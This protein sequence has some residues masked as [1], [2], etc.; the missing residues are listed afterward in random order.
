[1]WQK[2]RVLGFEGLN[3]GVDPAL[4][5]DSELQD[6][7]N[8]TADEVGR[9]IARRGSV[10][11]ARV[12]MTLA[13][14][15][16]SALAQLQG[17]WPRYLYDRLAAVAIHNGLMSNH[18]FYGIGE[19]VTEHPSVALQTDRYL[20][21]LARSYWR[22][23]SLL[24]GSGWTV[25]QAVGDVEQVD[26]DPED[27]STLANLVVPSGDVRDVI[28]QI[29]SVGAIPIGVLLV[30]PL[31][32]TGTSKQALPLLIP[33]VYARSTAPSSRGRARDVEPPLDVFNRLG[34]IY[35]IDWGIDAW[36]TRTD[37]P[38]ELE[39]R[40][41][42]RL[43]IA[44]P[45]HP[46]LIPTMPHGVKAAPFNWIESTVRPVQ[47]RN[48]FII[49]TRVSAITERG[50]EVYQHD[51]AVVNRYS[52]ETGIHEFQAVSNTLPKFDVSIVEVDPR[53]GIGQEND[54]TRGVETAMALYKFK[55]RRTIALGTRDHVDHDRIREDEE[56]MR[57]GHLS[58]DP[59]GLGDRYF[60][61]RILK[62][63][64]QL[65]H[66]KYDDPGWAYFNVVWSGNWEGYPKFIDMFSAMGLTGHRYVFTNM[67]QD[68]V[69]D[70]IGLPLVL[71]GEEE[72]DG[73]R[74]DRDKKPYIAASPVLW[75]DVKVRYYPCSG[76]RRKTA[77]GVRGWTYHDDLP[78]NVLFEGVEPVTKRRYPV[79]PDSILQYARVGMWRYRFVWEYEDGTLSSPSAELVCGDLLWSA[80]P[81]VY[82]SDAGVGIVNS[83]EGSSRPMLQQLVNDNNEWRPLYNAAVYLR[84]INRAN[85]VAFYSPSWATAIV[86]DEDRWLSADYLGRTGIVV[87]GTDVTSRHSPSIVPMPW[88]RE[89]WWV[90]S[91]DNALIRYTRLIKERLYSRQHPHAN[92]LTYI[93]VEV[94]SRIQLEGTWG[95][96]WYAGGNYKELRTLRLEVDG[97]GDWGLFSREGFP[98]LYY[99]GNPP[100]DRYPLPYWPPNDNERARSPL[101]DISGVE[102]W[103][104]V[105]VESP[106]AYIEIGDSWYLGTPLSY[107]TD[108]SYEGLMALLSVNLPPTLRIVT[109]GHRGSQPPVDWGEIITRGVAWDYN[110]LEAVTPSRP[111]PPEVL[112]RLLVRGYL[113]MQLVKPSW[114]VPVIG[115]LITGPALGRRDVPSVNWYDDGEWPVWSVNWWRRRGSSFAEPDGEQTYNYWIY[116]T[117]IRVYLKGARLTIPEQ[118]I[119]AFPSAV[120]YKAP[121]L[122]LKIPAEK[123]PP[124]ARRL[125]IFRTLPAIHNSDDGYSYSLVKKIDIPWVLEVD[126]IQPHRLDPS[127]KYCLQEGEQQWLYFFDDVRY[128]E[129]DHGVVPTEYEGMV[130]PLASLFAVPL[131][132][133]VYYANFAEKAQLLDPYNVAEGTRIVTPSGPVPPAL[134]YV[135]LP[136]SY[137]AY[138]G[139]ND[140]T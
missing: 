50:F 133:R 20:I 61:P 29:A 130:N 107:P 6:I 12:D 66:K 41:E 122:G 24:P 53:L 48:Y 102:F 35:S 71:E 134:G 55:C 83:H 11:A 17:D 56:Q 117:D 77:D 81:D 111:V 126:G 8:Y 113:E 14:T 87:F 73:F 96:M 82:M 33:H 123:I 125:W 39:P 44:P 78:Y 3:S 128:D 119:S 59:T 132:E 97:W 127:S 90:P 85:R 80:I 105:A 4:I 45:P 54:E 30:F 137:D 104:P 43:I 131:N 115:R 120:L 15:F 129:V 106:L 110:S 34:H 60:R 74:K 25:R 23:V 70:N 89:Y 95:I 32:N 38:N 67:K 136:E 21:V 135:V 68:T 19:F 88:S 86:S 79:A 57:S 5:K 94:P 99:V 63:K 140:P 98:H 101:R 22:P 27:E 91:S 114:V 37:S 108:P 1:M 49:P 16:P 2:T 28:N 139:E 26:Y 118:L 100:I 31:P 46:A 84:M 58:G 42:A 9:L 112:D 64:A 76:L 47:Y 52:H 40:I 7:L 75:E 138:S 93:T 92:N 65:Q 103:S 116:N 124:R 10:V 69:I 18:G 109:L 62:L 72:Y 51:L 121:R 36:T 13:R